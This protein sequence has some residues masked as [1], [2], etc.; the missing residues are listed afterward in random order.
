MPHGYL[1]YTTGRL[2][3]NA[4]ISRPHTEKSENTA[5]TWELWVSRDVLDQPLEALH[6]T[7]CVGE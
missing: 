1:I 4:K 2:F 7:D 6:E 3:V 5:I